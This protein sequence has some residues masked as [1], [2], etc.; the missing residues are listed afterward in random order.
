MASRLSHLPPLISPLKKVTHVS[1]LV[2]LYFLSLSSTL[3]VPLLSHVI[4]SYSSFFPSVFYSLHIYFLLLLPLLIFFK[5][6]FYLHHILIPPPLD[7][8]NSPS[9]PILHGWGV[10]KETWRCPPGRECATSQWIVSR[11]FHQTCCEGTYACIYVK[12]TVP[13][14]VWTYACVRVHAFNGEW[15][16]W[17]WGWFVERSVECESK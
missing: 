11:A 6:H 8:F 14:C 4:Y 1:S 10:S 7:L 17:M 15:L 13:V 16:Q 9:R 12:A 3:Y 2:M 5:V